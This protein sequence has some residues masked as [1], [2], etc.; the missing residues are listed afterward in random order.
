MNL[1]L[2]K[3]FINNLVIYLYLITSLIAVFKVGSHPDD[4]SNFYGS[5]ESLRKI[6]NIFNKEFTLNKNYIIEEYYG[7]FISIPASL[8]SH[9]S[10]YLKDYFELEIY[11]LLIIYKL[12]RAFFFISLYEGFGLPL[13]EAFASKI[14]A[15]FSDTTSLK[16]ICGDNGFR[17]DPN[18]INLINEY[19]RNFILNRS[20]GMNEVD[21]SFEYSK[22]FNW[23]NTVK[24]T[25]KI[26]DFFIP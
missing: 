12:A 10:I 4:S 23:E 7:Q 24:E 17:V 19:M 18:N 3:H 2:K 14:P 8:V 1:K 16:E 5:N 21:K 20:F 15:V 9:F 6:L 22:L 11:D 25:Q 26:Y 13:I